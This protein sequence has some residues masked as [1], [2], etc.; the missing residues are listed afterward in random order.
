MSD[1]TSGTG[2][3][4]AF[5]KVKWLVSWYVS[6]VKNPIPWFQIAILSLQNFVFIFI[7][8]FKIFYLFIREHV[9][10]EKG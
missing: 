3:L 1:E 8:R 2:G 6:S 7:L 9:W 10:G 4:L 5:P